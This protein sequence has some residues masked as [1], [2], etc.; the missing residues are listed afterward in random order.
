MARRNAQGRFVKGSSRALVVSRPATQVV[1]R[2]GSK[3]VLVPASASAG[4]RRKAASG[5]ITKHIGAE[6]RKGAVI[7]GAVL[8]Y[9]MKN[10]AEM[11]AK[12]PKLA[13]T[14]LI[15]IAIGAHLYAQDNPG[16]YIDHVATAAAAIAAYEIGQRGFSLTG[17]DGN[18][19][20]AEW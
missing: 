3:I 13:G 19:N 16:G 8:G 12:I 10:Q 11:M 18:G 17:D 6:V 4:G 5:R 2:P 1:R 7:G 14:P 9:L 15:T 20:P